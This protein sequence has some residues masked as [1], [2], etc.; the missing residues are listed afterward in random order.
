MNIRKKCGTHQ[1]AEELKVDEHNVIKT[2]IMEAD[3]EPIVV[4]MHGD[5]EVSTKNLA[6]LLGVKKVEPA[7]Q[8]TLQKIQDICLVEQAH[9]E[10]NENENIYRRKHNGTG[11]YIY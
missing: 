8:K 5:R 11:L 9:L 1:T 6:R 2:L 3:G 4:L 10:Q 7:K